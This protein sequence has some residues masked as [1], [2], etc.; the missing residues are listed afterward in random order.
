MRTGHFFSFILI[1][2][3]FFTAC[4]RDRN[5]LFIS[6]EILKAD[7]QIIYLKKLGK[8]KDTI[9]D[10]TLIKNNTFEL[11][12]NIARPTFLSLELKKGKGITLIAHPGDDIVARSKA[13]KIN[14]NYHIEGSPESET[15]MKLNQ[16]MEVYYKKVDS[17]G[18]VYRDLQDSVPLR[19]LRTRL[20]SIYEKYYNIAKEEVLTYIDNNKNKL[21]GL[22]APY[23]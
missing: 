11:K 15:I 14:Q 1:S 21:A 12:G 9:L 10:S 6:G 13:P 19:T 2:L 23:Q 22:I 18:K 20:D 8:E 3:F 4:Q 7:K 17:L 16:K 5:N